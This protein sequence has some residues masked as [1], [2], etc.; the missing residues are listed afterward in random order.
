[1]TELPTD[2]DE[3][4]TLRDQ[5]FR[6]LDKRG[7]KVVSMKPDAGK[8]F[9]AGATQASL[10]RM[11]ERMAKAGGRQEADRFVKLFSPGL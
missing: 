8:R 6:E 11:K 7:M 10:E 1:M 5:E 3:V 4:Q 9:S 2:E